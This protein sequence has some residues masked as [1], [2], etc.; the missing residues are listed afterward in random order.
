MGQP[1]FDFVEEQAKNTDIFCFQEVFRAGDGAPVLSSRAHMYMYQELCEKLPAFEGVF[2]AKGSGYDYDSKVSWPLELGMAVFAKKDLKIT[3]SGWFSYFDTNGYPNSP[4]EEGM[5]G[6]HTVSM[7]LANGMT[8]HIINVHGISIPG[9]KL[10]TNERLLQSERIIECANK[11]PQD[12]VIICGDFNLMP[13][14]ESI[15]MIEN[16]GFK[17][18]IKD[19]NITNTRNEVQWA[20]FPGLEKQHFADYMFVSK[21]IPVNDFLVP[22]NEISDHLPMILEI[23][24]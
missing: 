20:K 7:K 19:Y 9:N 3:G 2:A 15:S 6:L 11:F 13:E 16:I 22:Y 4:L 24:I 10:D 21:N 8:M 17:N 5:A 14:T 12:F 18:L 23:N 1:L